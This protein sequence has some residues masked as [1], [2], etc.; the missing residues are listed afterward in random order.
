[1][2][3]EGHNEEEVGV[4]LLDGYD[5]FRRLQRVTNAQRWEADAI[6]NLAVHSIS[7][8]FKDGRRLLMM[9]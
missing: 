7:T 6:A 5:G 1:M 8:H 4:G 3:V 2:V 9:Y